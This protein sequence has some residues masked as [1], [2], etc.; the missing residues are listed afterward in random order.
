VLAATGAAAAA[1]TAGFSAT[2]FSVA[3]AGVAGFATVVGNSLTSALL[4]P[5]EAIVTPVSTTPQTVLQNEFQDFIV[6]LLF[7][8]LM[9]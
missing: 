9:D 3:A 4:Q 1:I 7:S 2:A 8:F 5:K 6:S